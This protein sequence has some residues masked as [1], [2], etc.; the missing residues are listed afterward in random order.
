MHAREIFHA[1]R[2]EETAARVIRREQIDV[3]HSHFGWPAGLGGALAA[4]VTG[5][6]V[7][8]S[9]LAAR[10]GALLSNPALA[11]RLGQAAR[12]RVES[13][14]DYSRMMAAVRG[15]YDSVRVTEDGRQALLSR[16]S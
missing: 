4:H 8:T 2:I 7:V 9:A 6:P 12:E 15:V 16:S 3:I 14:H 11:A 5:I 1:L 13:R 10:I